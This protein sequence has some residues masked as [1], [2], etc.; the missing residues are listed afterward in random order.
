MASSMIL[1]LYNCSIVRVLSL[2]SSVIHGFVTEPWHSRHV[3]FSCEHAASNVLEPCALSR[4]HALFCVGAWCSDPGT[5]VLSF[6]FVSGF[7][8]LCSMF[9]LVLWACGLE[10]AWPRALMSTCVVFCVAHS[11]CFIRLFCHWLHAFMLSCLVWVFSFHM[12]GDL[13]APCLESICELLALPAPPKLLALPV[14]PKYHPSPAGATLALPVPPVPPKLL[15]LPSP[16]KLL[17]LPAPPKLKL[18]ALDC[19]SLSG[20]TFPFLPGHMWPSG[21]SCWHWLYFPSSPICLCVLIFLVLF[22]M[23]QSCAVMFLSCSW[24]PLLGFIF[25]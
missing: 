7:G 14:P 13:F 10:F 15:A 5:H 19:L 22:I 2:R 20:S 8:Y 1:H 21:L 17:A 24:C 6:G 25:D 16:P 23:C 12:A 18:L 3:L 4:L 9:C 11:S